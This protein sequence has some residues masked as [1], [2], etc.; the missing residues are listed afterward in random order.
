VSKDYEVGFSA[1][2]AVRPLSVVAGEISTGKT[3]VLEL[4]DYCLGASRHPRHPEIQRQARSGLLEVELSGEANV[5]ERPLFSTEQLAYVHRCSMDD[6][7]RPHAKERRVIDPPGAPNSLS[8]LLLEHCGLAGLSLKQAPTRADSP[9]DPLSFRNLMWLAFLPN[10]RLDN[11]QL[12]HE[13]F[14]VE[15]H[16]LRQV[17]E[18]IFDVHD[19]QLAKLGEALDAA[20][21]QRRALLAEIESLERFLSDE[22]VPERIEAVAALAELESQEQQLATRLAEVSATM[23]ARTE[24]ADEVRRD[25]AA[26]AS[27]ARQAAAVVRDR[28]TLL[29]RLLPLRGQYAEDEAKLIFYEEARTLFDPLRIDTCPSCLQRLAESPTIDA[30]ECTLCGQPIVSVSEPIDVKTELAAVRA[31]KREIDR[32]VEQVEDELT[33]ARST[34]SAANVAE[35]AAQARLDSEVAQ[36]LAPFVAEREQLVRER[37]DARGRRAELQRQLSWREGLERRR[38]DLTRL[39]ARMRELREQIA[40]RRAARPSRDEV[41]TDLS[42]R[43]TTILREFGFPKLESPEA[44]YL[45]ANFVPHV[46]GNVYR[47]IGSSGALTLIALA[48]QLSVFERAFE[49]GHPH[50]G[51]LMIDSPQKNLVPEDTAAPDEYRDEA[52]AR[53]VWDHLISW[54]DGAGRHAQLIVVDNRPPP[55]AR[56]AIVVEYSRRADDPPYGLIDNE[57]E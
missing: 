56:P 35:Q 26:R 6:L 49:L 9:V 7:D 23:R 39:E 13:H 22:D 54:A 14:Y 32:Y 33:Q 25:F 29:K 43:F 3:S 4:I 18:I 20:G 28:E 40:A 21:E 24:F 52:I 30:G 11:R 17:I 53:R 37:E 5:I 38:D 44:P 48:W 51:F 8:M 41:V 42:E 57:T 50:P 1:D 47:E 34:Y 27:A 19:E 10:Q 55:R 45:D 15:E 16:K 2:G 36:A 31:R 46:R 12:L